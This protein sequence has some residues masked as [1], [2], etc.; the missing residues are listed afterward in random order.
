M[1][2]EGVEKKEQA[3]YL[4]K[5]MCD[6][7]QGY[8]YSKPVPEEEVQSSFDACGNPSADRP[9]EGVVHSR[10][11]RASRLFTGLSTSSTGCFPQTDVCA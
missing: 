8:Y 10:T 6:M 2:A 3:E 11:I 9:G 5:H 4:A 1:V 7:M